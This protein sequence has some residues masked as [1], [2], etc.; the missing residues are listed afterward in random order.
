MKNFESIFVLLLLAILLILDNF[1]KSQNDTDWVNQ[2]EN[3]AP[4]V[5]VI[6]G[7]TDHANNDEL[8]WEPKGFTSELEDCEL[9]LPDL[10]T[11]YVIIEL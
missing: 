7:G 1:V 9:A 2:F 5:L 4:E 3:E 6:Y 8:F 11:K 10:P